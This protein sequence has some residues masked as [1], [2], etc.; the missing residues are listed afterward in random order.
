MTRITS[1]LVLLSGILFLATPG[2]TVEQLKFGTAVKMAPSFY[3]PTLAAQEKGFWR[4]RGLEVEWVPFKGGPPM[5]HAVAS[6][7][8]N[9]GGTSAINAIRGASGGVPIVI[10]ANLAHQEWLFWVRADSRFR[11]A[12]DLKGAKIGVFRFAGPA[13][14]KGRFVVRKLGLAREVTFVASGGFR[15]STALLQRGAVDVLVLPRDMMAVLLIKRV[16]RELLSLDDYLPKEWAYNTLIASRRFIE[17]KPGTVKD[18]LRAVLK[19]ISYLRQDP[20][21]SKEKI[22]AMSGHSNAVAEHIYNH[23]MELF[24]RDGRISSQ[25]L[26]NIIKFLIDF[27]IIAKDKAPKI[28]DVFTSRF[29]E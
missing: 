3:L 23:S 27:G 1:W 14:A 2:M 17:E 11:K 7:V 20:V 24:T 21:W 28:E 25:A 6:G 26:E 13:D 8:I 19:S 4:E 16:V 29:I 15:S 18:V 9:V 10:V 22:K 5:N 12:Q